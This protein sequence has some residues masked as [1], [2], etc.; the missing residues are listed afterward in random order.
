MRFDDLLNRVGDTATRIAATANHTVGSAVDTA[1]Q[2][3]GRG[4]DAV[5]L[6]GAA[7]SVTDA[8]DAVADRL[9]DPVPKNSWKKVVT[10]PS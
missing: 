4:L 7:H 1:A 9:G 3:V 2:D 5:G 10:R 6:H 8:G